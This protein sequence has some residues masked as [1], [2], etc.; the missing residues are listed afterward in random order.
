M[1]QDTKGTISPAPTANKHVGGW[2]GSRAI[3]SPVPSGY[4]NSSPRAGS[5]HFCLQ[6]T[7]LIHLMCNHFVG[8]LLSGA[9]GFDPALP[10]LC[11]GSGFQAAPDGKVSAPR[12]GRKP[13]KVNDLRDG[14]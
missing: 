7:L 5:P 3:N 11:L 14:F 4:T 8:R 12:C 6:L 2:L 1:H 9:S 10:V 13:D